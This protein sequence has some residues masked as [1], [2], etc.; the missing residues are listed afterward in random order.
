MVIIIL[1]LAAQR[2]KIGCLP[3]PWS[4][5]P[6]AGAKLHIKTVCLPLPILTEGRGLGVLSLRMFLAE[7]VDNGQSNTP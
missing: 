4:F 6:K 5:A 2:M 7:M 3:R 1:N